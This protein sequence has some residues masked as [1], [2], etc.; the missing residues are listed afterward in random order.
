MESHHG[1]LHSSDNLWR[2]V[3]LRF[4]KFIKKRVISSCAVLNDNFPFIEDDLDV[5]NNDNEKL[6][7]ELEPTETILRRRRQQKRDDIANIIYQF[8]L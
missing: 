5:E 3:D 8:R 7:Q 6:K 1:Y 4:T 2:Q